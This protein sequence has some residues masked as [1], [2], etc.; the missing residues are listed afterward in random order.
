M[1][2]VYTHKAIGAFGEGGQVWLELNPPS[3]NY[4]FTL[5]HR[6]SMTRLFLS[7]VLCKDQF[8]CTLAEM[9]E[10]CWTLL[11]QI[12]AYIAGTAQ[13]GTRQDNLAAAEHL[14]LRGNRR[15]V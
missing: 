9:P 15:A 10:R 14:L 1:T 8:S 13:I 12:V 5:S 6:S 7:T 11:D 2:N 4:V 3:S